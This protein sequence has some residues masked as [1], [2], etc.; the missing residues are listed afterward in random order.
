MKTPNL[1]AGLELSNGQPAQLKLFI[2]R[3]LKTQDMAAWQQDPKGFESWLKA[4][5]CDYVN[6]LCVVIR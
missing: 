5:I 2:A 6:N 1:I 3:L 4:A